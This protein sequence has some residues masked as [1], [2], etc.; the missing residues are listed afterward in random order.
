MRVLKNGKFSCLGKGCHTVY[1]DRTY[2][3]QAIDSFRQVRGLAQQLRHLGPGESIEK[4]LD[5]LFAD[6]KGYAPLRK[7]FAAMRFYLQRVISGCG[8]EWDRQAN[9]VTNYVGLVEEIDKRWISKGK[10]VCF[11]S[12]NYDLLLDKAMEPLGQRFV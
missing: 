3:G 1:E 6:A 4:R 9:G 7:Q 5:D 10:E 2:F 8:T 12:F 11:V